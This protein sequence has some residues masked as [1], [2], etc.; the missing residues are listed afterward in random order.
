MNSRSE[1]DLLLNSRPSLGGISSTS[2]RKSFSTSR[3]SNSQGFGSR[4]NRSKFNL[5]NMN[6]NG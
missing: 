2:G 4:V 3:S 1:N 6:M 5:D